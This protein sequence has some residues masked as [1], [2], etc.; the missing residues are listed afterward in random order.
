MLAVS[1]LGDGIKHA[2]ACHERH[3]KTHQ[4]LFYGVYCDGNAH[5]C[6]FR[7]DTTN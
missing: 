6:T 2:E 4:H 7:Y 3:A 1:P 5:I